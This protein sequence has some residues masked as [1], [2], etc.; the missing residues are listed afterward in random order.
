MHTITIC[1]QKG[2]VAKTTT[3]LNLACGLALLEHRA[4]AQRPGRVL[5]VDMDPQG[6]ASTIASSGLFSTQAANAPDG[7]QSNLANLLVD[8]APP[9]TVDLI[10][11]ARIPT[12]PQN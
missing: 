6:N 4:D 2:G 5:L 8:D 3:A 11:P 1:N 9:P 12:L 10:H 7:Q